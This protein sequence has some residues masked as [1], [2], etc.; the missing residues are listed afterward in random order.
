MS[1][2]LILLFAATTA[3]HASDLTA[4][5][6]VIEGRV[7]DAE[8][9][10]VLSG[11]HISLDDE[12]AVAQSAV[13]GSFVIPEVAP[14]VHTVSAQMLGYGSV[15]RE[16]RARADERLQLEIA[17]SQQ[18]LELG[19]ITVTVP[20]GGYV[21]DE[22]A[23]GTKMPLPLIETPQAISVITRDQMEAQAPKTMEEVVRYTAGVRAEM[24]GPD[25][26]GDWFRLRGGSEGSTVLDGLRLPLSGSWGNVRNEPYAFERVEVLRG[27]SSVLYGQNGP[28]GVVNLVS[29]LPLAASQREIQAQ[30][31]NH[32]YRQI[33]ADVTGN[34]TND[35]SV[36]YRFVGL[37]KESGTQVDHADEERQY[38]APSLTWLPGPATS[39]TA[40]GQYQRDRS[41][42]TVGFFPWT[43]TLLPAPNGRIPDDTFIGEPEWDSYGGERLRAGYH[44]EHRLGRWTVRHDLR[45]EDVDGHV[46]GMY[47]NF[48]EAGF[49]DD[50]RSVNRTWYAT[51]TDTRITNVDFLANGELSFG[52][53]THSVLFGVDGLWVRDVNPSTEGEA[54]PLDVYEPSYGRFPMPELDFGPQPGARTHT[55]Q[56]GVTVQDQ[57]HLD[58]RWI[59]LAG[60]RLD[61]ATNSVNGSPDAGSEDTA[62]SS[63]FGLVYRS[64]AGWAPY[65]SYS[66]SFASVGGAD[67]HGEPYE[68]LRGTQ[69]EAGMKWSPPDRPLVLT[70]AAY[71]IEEENRLTTD[72]DDPVNQVQHG[73]VTAQGVELEA[74]ASI[75]AWDIAANYTY[76]DAKVTASSDPDDPYLNKRLHS[77]PE[78][79][80]A[81]WTVHEFFVG[82]SLGISAGIGVR[83]VG[84]TWDGTDSLAT[85]STTLADALLSIDN[86]QWRLA[87]NASNLFDRA[88]VATC[89][90]RG[91][92]WYGNRRKVFGSLAYR[93]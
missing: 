75:A 78:H 47:A 31:G 61:R 92:C 34:V 76:T 32:D 85:P 21:A 72:P 77:I 93:W 68:P 23:S 18:A 1:R 84:E 90:E 55:R 87:V 13:D 63:R 4:Q 29:K 69:I 36:L 14:G 71:E 46:R 10:A 38:V 5:T 79:S 20:G 51:R 9:R 70:A 37:A 17:L 11:V 24:Y 44:V 22:A 28:G 59:V 6:A 81:L 89:L 49:L 35:G 82:R 50:G 52:P 40:Y 80:A 27:P 53:T 33:A 54:T 43:G 74:T 7:R 83:Y 56:L 30:F 62:W 15:E 60:L 12:G 58:D 19:A 86:G 41:K 67:V 45:H 25:N 48:W 64:P 39:F 73:A 91:D 57:V 42:N 2:L 26:R 3:I 66:E 16:I 65:A 88:Y 8:T